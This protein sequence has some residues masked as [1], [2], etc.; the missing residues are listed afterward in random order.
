M[1]LLK[2]QKK[3]IADFSNRLDFI[4]KGGL[5]TD[6]DGTV[7][8]ERNGKHLIPAEVQQGLTDI[9]DTS[10]PII[11]NTIRFP[12]SVIKTFAFDW[13]HMSKTSVP[14]VSLNG[15]QIGYIDIDKKS[16]FTFQEVDA[17]PLREEDVKKFISDIEEILGNGGSVM[18]FYYPRKWSKGEI[19][20]TPEKEKVSE[21]KAKYRSAS[22]VYSTNIQSFKEDLEAEDIS[23]IFLLATI[24]DANASYL[25]T[26]H[27]N[28]YTRQ[29][30]DKLHGAKKIISYLDREIE[31]FI[32]AGDTPMDVFLKDVG[33]V[34]KVG[35]MDLNFHCKSP[36]IQ[37][38]HVPD[39]GEVFT[40]VAKSCA[41]SK[42]YSL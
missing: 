26:N 35:N 2:E 36:T 31:N 28:F 25:H 13:Y 41:D 23:M 42:L 7:I 38:E 37:L 34:I 8:Q 40:E 10:C 9:Y 30:V 29:N 33:Q 1:S 12:L 3:Q 24:M 39:I 21:I 19:I 22:H 20:W 14:L 15:S 32:G 17:F 11:L 5:M 18:A 27:K 4:N 6:L 16:N